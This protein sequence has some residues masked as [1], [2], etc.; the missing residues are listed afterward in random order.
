MTRKRNPVGKRTN[1]SP[2]AGVSTKKNPSSPFPDYPDYKS[3]LPA[4]YVTA[5]HCG[6]DIGTESFS[7]KFLG[8]GEGYKSPPLGPGI[9]CATKEN[10]ARIYCK[11]AKDA[12]LYEVRIPTKGLYSERWGPAHLSNAVIELFERESKRHKWRDRLT[13]RILQLVDMMGAK[14][15]ASELVKVG[16]KGAWEN[17]AD[18]A[19]G[20]EIAVFD[21]SIIKI[22]RKEPAARDNPKA[23][24][25]H[26]TNPKKT[27]RKAAKKKASLTVKAKKVAK[28]DMGR[29]G[30]GA[31]IGALALGPIGAVAGAGIAMAT[32][33]ETSKKGAKKKTKAN[34]SLAA[35]LKRLRASKAAKAATA[36]AKGQ[37]SS[38]TAAAGAKGERRRRLAAKF[39]PGKYHGCIGQ[40]TKSD[41]DEEIVAVNKLIR[42][43][44][45]NE[46]PSSRNLRDFRAA[47]DALL[48]ERSSRATSN[49]SGK[50]ETPP[51][52][53]N[54]IA[55]QKTPVMKHY[56]KEVH[57]MAS[58][59]INKGTDDRVA[60]QMAFAHYSKKLPAKN[61]SS[62]RSRYRDE[63]RVRSSPP[64]LT[65]EI[66]QLAKIEGITSAVRLHD[67]GLIEFVGGHWVPTPNGEEILESAGLRRRKKNPISTIRRRGQFHTAFT[68]TSDDL[69]LIEKYDAMSQFEG[70]SPR[71]SEALLKKMHQVDA[72]P[73][74]VRA[75][76]MLDKLTKQF[77]A[78]RTAH[79]D[80]LTYPG[81]TEADIARAA[82]QLGDAEKR[83]SLYAEMRNM[84]PRDLSRFVAHA[85][86]K[87]REAVS[88]RGNPGRKPRSNPISHILRDGKVQATFTPTPEDRRLIKKWARDEDLAG[89]GPRQIEAFMI[90]L[91]KWDSVFS[92]PEVKDLLDNVESTHAHLLNEREYGTRGEIDRA[93]RAA[94][95]A[96]RALASV[97]EA[98]GV[99]GA[100]RSPHVERRVGKISM[101][102]PPRGSGRY[103]NPKKKSAKS[104]PLAKIPP[105][106]REKKAREIIAANIATEVAAG[107]PRK[108]AVAI[109]LNS[110]RKDAPKLMERLYPSPKK[111]D[112]PGKRLS[113]S[114][115]DRV[116]E[117]IEQRLPGATATDGGIVR[118]GR[119]RVQVVFYPHGDT[120][121]LTVVSGRKT[122]STDRVDTAIRMAIELLTS[123]TRSSR[124]SNS[125]SAN[126]K[127]GK[128]D[129]F[130]FTGVKAAPRVAGAADGTRPRP[131]AQD[132]FAFTGVKARPKDQEDFAF[133]G[134]EARPK[135]AVSD[136]ERMSHLKLYREL[137][138]ITPEEHAELA[139]LERKEKEREKERAARLRMSVSGMIENPGKKKAA[140]KSS[141][142]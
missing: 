71:E 18:G 57:Q 16:V 17:L 33:K 142:R 54:R 70:R 87:R 30:I 105:R 81:H 63:E 109:A 41:L 1:R 117:G 27:A 90:K 92:E 51:Q 84:D 113:A 53:R 119:N 132:A 4:P 118:Y 9:Y 98:R 82:K 138:G 31:G 83:L 121:N 48:A 28:T 127:P 7:L 108:Q 32:K 123:P 68:P 49:P 141:K 44:E 104:N 64:L 36:A 112:N 102:V 14:Q 11:Y 99:K 38:R 66:G 93:G 67:L 120:H 124:A 46:K 6:R 21:P 12:V 128:K 5:Y 131:K 130:V 95:E 55:Q 40:M 133:T 47:R 125:P 10:I 126:P 24:M 91:R 136:Y 73:D 58:R 137:T 107:R 96:K 35:D 39:N 22:I 76:N 61:P 97:A 26:V 122:K 94:G 116:I 37:A 80:A 65:G 77:L 45:S 62:N 3:E 134:V 129:A 103:N 52:F 114:S 23:N 100:L 101:P 2:S 42:R 140:K 135:R 85:E 60:Y 111:L 115:A 79:H 110:A 20:Q 34:P 15:A 19:N 74:A 8:T 43:V 50:K 78:K 106:A 13:S 88:R 25:I 29:A 59:L 69:R 86:E 139:E 89:K 56:S 75:D 72:A